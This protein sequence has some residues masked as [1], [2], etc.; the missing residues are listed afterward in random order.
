MYCSA[1]FAHTIAVLEKNGQHMLMYTHIPDDIAGD[2]IRRGDILQGAAAISRF[3]FGSESDRRRVYFLV[4][5]GAL[6]HFRLGGT[7]CARRSTLLDWIEKQESQSC[8]R[9]A[10]ATEAR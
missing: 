3:L 1:T 9:L 8:S 5:S 10:V 7:V 2:D 4:E 6:P